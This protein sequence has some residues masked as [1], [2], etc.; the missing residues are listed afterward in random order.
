MKARGRDYF[1]MHLAHALGMTRRQ[2]LQS[3]DSVEMTLWE[4]Y[5]TEVNAP[6][7]KQQK[8]QTKEQIEGALKNFFAVKSKG[9][10]A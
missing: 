3:M 10:H 8:K 2:L 7:E 4:A 9:K 1:V 6:P 5:F